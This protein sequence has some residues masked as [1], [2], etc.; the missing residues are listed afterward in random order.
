ME[1]VSGTYFQQTTQCT[2][3]KAQRTF[4]LALF[5][6][7]IS[8]CSSL[9]AQ[10]QNR[11]QAI[12]SFDTTSI[13]IGEQLHLNLEVIVPTEAQLAFPVFP[14]TIGKIDIVNKSALDTIKSADGKFSTY[15]QTL[16]IT[17]FDA[18]IYLLQPFRFYYKLPA[19]QNIDSISTEELM[20]QVQTIPVDT[21]LAIKDIK[22]PLDV[23][24][25]LIE[26][27][28]Y[29]IIG[30]IILAIILIINQI[31][32]RRKRKRGIIKIK[33]PLRPA[34]EIALEDLQKIQE[35][36]LWQDG[37][38]KQYQSSVSDII[39]MY[40]ENRFSIPAL[41][42]TSDET[43]N[44]LK[45]NLVSAEAFEKL[46]YILL[47]A[48][49]VKFAKAVPLGTE[50]EQVMQYAKEFVMF[51]KSVSKDDFDNAEKGKEAIA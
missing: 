43:L 18:G 28:P 29:I 46:K 19:K 44:H 45:R 37:F 24:F 12:A 2:A 7:L 26:A 3:H 15:K 1:K 48:D 20:L 30:A 47:L 10:A 50:N 22:P 42:L 32:K 4:Y 6:L 49:T 11:I 13:K 27:M 16:T 40:I 14:D 9:F 33:V 25:S 8:S 39:R 38:Y 21:T 36:K 31:I 51:T 35:Q 5:F 34:H 23:P 17:C 41:E